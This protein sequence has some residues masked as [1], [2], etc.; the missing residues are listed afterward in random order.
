MG[1]PLAKHEY[2]SVDALFNNL[3]S[4]SNIKEINSPVSEQ[5]CFLP[6]SEVYNLSYYKKLFGDKPWCKVSGQALVLKDSGEQSYVL[7]HWLA[8]E[9]NK[10]EVRQV[11]IKQTLI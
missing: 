6:S 4:S 5:Y 8:N 10:K 9:K 7:L 1:Y 11:K 2:A 3:V